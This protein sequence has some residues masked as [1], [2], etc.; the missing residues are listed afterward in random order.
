MN[1]LIKTNSNMNILKSIAILFVL[2]LAMTSCN[3]NNGCGDPNALNYEAGGK[4]NGHCSYTKVIFYAPSDR[5]GGTADKVVKIEIS[6]G[7]LPYDEV[8]GTITTFDHEIPSACISPIGAFE[9]E[10]PN[11]DVPYTF[12]TRYYYEAG[13]N[14]PGDTYTIQASNSKECELIELTL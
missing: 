7:A 13:F 6:F 1:N 2:F 5:V 3:N 12:T 4:S 11:A 8:V 10:L 14:E 9:H